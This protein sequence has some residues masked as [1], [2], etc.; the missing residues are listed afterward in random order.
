MKLSKNHNFLNMNV[1]Y[2]LLYK[3]PGAQDVF[4]PI[5]GLMGIGGSL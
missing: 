1:A 4:Q 2:V 3:S 5:P